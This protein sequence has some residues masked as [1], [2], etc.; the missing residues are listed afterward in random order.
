ML[1]QSLIGR[2]ETSKDLAIFT[3]A[4]LRVYYTNAKKA[5]GKIGP[6]RTLAFF[7]KRLW[8]T[9][10]RSWKIQI[11]LRRKEGGGFKEHPNTN[12]RRSLF[13][14]FVLFNLWNTNHLKL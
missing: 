2:I 8:T 1:S 14:N 9:N 11:P 7:W 4:A 12:R 3:N 5:S 6:L 13:S 10:Y